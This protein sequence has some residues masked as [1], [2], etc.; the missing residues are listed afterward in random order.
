MLLTN[1]C[2]FQSK[3]IQVYVIH[4][5]KNNHSFKKDPDWEN[6]NLHGIK[7]YFFGRFGLEV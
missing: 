4:I 3:K 1:S 6:I 2:L 5:Q 7:K